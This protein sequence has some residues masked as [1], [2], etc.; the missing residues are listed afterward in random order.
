MGESTKVGSDGKADIRERASAAAP[1][2]RVVHRLN[3]EGDV[4]GGATGYAARTGRR[5]RAAEGDV[6]ECKEFVDGNRAVAVAVANAP[7]WPGR[8][9]RLGHPTLCTTSAVAGAASTLPAA[10]RAT[11]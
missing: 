9:T 7:G 5:L 11:L 6:H 8:G 10:S 2:E 3:E 1:V 4:H